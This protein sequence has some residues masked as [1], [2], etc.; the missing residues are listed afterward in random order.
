MND[1]KIKHLANKRHIVLDEE[2][3]A[4]LKMKVSDDSSF[5]ST[6]YFDEPI[7]SNEVKDYLLSYKVRLAWKKGVK[8]EI[9]S[10]VI[11]ETEQKVYDSAIRNAFFKE[12][13]IIK[14]KN[15]I[16]A[17]LSFIMF[18][19]GTTFLILLFILNNILGNSFGIWKEIIDIIAWVFIWESVDLFAIDR[20]ENF[21]AHRMAKNVTTAK[22]VFKKLDDE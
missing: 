2:N 22:I 10:N 11:D 5:L 14:R 19:L 17:I 6:Y 21:Y 18:L 7:I 12:L 13:E 15:K 3:R 1:K 16:A 9:I 8:I 4:I 20:L